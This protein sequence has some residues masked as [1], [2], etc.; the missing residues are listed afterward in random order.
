[1]KKFYEWI[2][3]SSF[4]LRTMGSCNFFTF[5]YS[6]AYE[7]KIVIQFGLFYRIIEFNI[8]KRKEGEI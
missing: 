4:S 2:K 3:M 6:P 5:W 7:Y 8:W 1:M